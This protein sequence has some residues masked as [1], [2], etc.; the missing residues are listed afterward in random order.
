MLSRIQDPRLLRRGIMNGIDT[1]MWDPAH[2]EHLPPP[3]LFDASSVAQGKA[4][5]KALLQKQL[6]LKFAPD[7]PLICFIGRLASVLY[8]LRVFS[9]GNHRI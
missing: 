5:A 6:G 9:P 4:A 2:D 1:E 7:V 8:G 3:V